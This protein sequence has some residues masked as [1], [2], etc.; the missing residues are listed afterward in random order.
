[1]GYPKLSL[2]VALLAFGFTDCRKRI[3]G[4][5]RDLSRWKTPWGHVNIKK[6]P[7]GQVIFLYPSQ[8]EKPARGDS[9]PTISIQADQIVESTP[10]SANGKM[11]A[12]WDWTVDASIHDINQIKAIKAH[13]SSTKIAEMS[14]IIE[15]SIV[16]RV[17]NLDNIIE[18]D[19]ILLQSFKTHLQSNKSVIAIIINS[20]TDTKTLS[21]STEDVSQKL[22]SVEVEEY[23]DV[24]FSVHYQCSI[25]YNANAI[26]LLKSNRTPVFFGYNTFVLS[27][28][29]TK[30]IPAEF[31]ADIDEYDLSPTAMTK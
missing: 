13:F 30:V 2:M 4:Q 5:C 29:Q 10:E 21:L 24:E 3:D 1:M 20:V 8:D 14:V 17:R 31:P 22:G 26:N 25:D 11:E 23:G 18:S 19:K 7:L 27:P 9:G 12:K 28:D 16:K 6:Y 15:D